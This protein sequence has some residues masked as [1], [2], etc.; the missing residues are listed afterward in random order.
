M[1]NSAT[2]YET[3][4]RN[5]YPDLDFTIYD[6]LPFVVETCGG[7]G[8]AARS[9]CKELRRR[10]AEKIFGEVG[11]EDDWCK[12]GDPLQT[13]INVEVQ[14]YNSQ[15]ILERKPIP[16][17]LIVSRLVKSELALA[18]RRSKMM[19]RI[20]A[21]KKSESSFK[22]KSEKYQRKAKSAR[23]V[24][25]NVMRNLK[26][27]HRQLEKDDNIGASGAKFQR[28]RSWKDDPPDPPKE[29][30]SPSSPRIKDTE[31]LERAMAIKI[32]TTGQS[33]S[34]KVQVIHPQRYCKPAGRTAMEV[35]YPQPDQLIH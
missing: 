15:M 23:G 16:E 22:S 13:A 18:K 11:G 29:L 3:V 4:K 26:Q 2:A 9:F 27:A 20:R 21:K 32:K 35:E 8:D 1:G 17:D 12:Y 33:T 25:E 31:V 7:V 24:S 5:T 6:F 28:R 14:R 19:D 10:R 30:F 34:T